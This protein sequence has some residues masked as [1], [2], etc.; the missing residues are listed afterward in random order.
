MLPF[1]DAMERIAGAVPVCMLH[2]IWTCVVDQHYIRSALAGGKSLQA[3]PMPI[4]GVLYPP[5]FDYHLPE[6]LATACQLGHDLH[7]LKEFDPSNVFITEQVLRHNFDPRIDPY[8][9][10]NHNY[11]DDCHFLDDFE[12]HTLFENDSRAFSDPALD[13][14]DDDGWGPPK[15][16]KS[17]ETDFFCKSKTPKS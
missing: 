8:S 12:V 2:L 4:Q 16:S 11:K 5:P 7:Y 17:H 9:D 10:G 15:G 13:S 1:D 14:V 6:S 3:M